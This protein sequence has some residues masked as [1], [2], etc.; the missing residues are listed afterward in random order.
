MD[1]WRVN[2][3]AARYYAR[4]RP[5]KIPA[6][7]QKAMKLTDAEVQEYF[8]EALALLEKTNAED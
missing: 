8:G 4:V 7:L 5:K 2:V 6:L 1:E 3:D